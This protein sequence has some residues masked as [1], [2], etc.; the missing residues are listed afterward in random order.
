[1]KAKWKISEMVKK[2]LLK[3]E[4]FWLNPF[5]RFGIWSPKSFCLDML[6]RRFPNRRF[7]KKRE[8]KNSTHIGIPN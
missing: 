5:I 7:V 2:L 8:I 4:D 1:M 6:R 3:T